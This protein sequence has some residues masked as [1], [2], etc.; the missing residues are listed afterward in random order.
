MEAKPALRNKTR[1]PGSDARV[2]N[3]RLERISVRSRRTSS[4]K[5]ISGGQHSRRTCGTA[6]A[7]FNRRDLPLRI[8]RVLHSPHG[9]NCFDRNSVP[10]FRRSIYNGLDSRP[11]LC[12]KGTSSTRAPVEF[13]LLA[14][15][16]LHPEVTP[17][18]RVILANNEN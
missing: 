17:E 15:M 10:A 3:K 7:L 5:A 9:T 2:G 13:S 8:R 16:T 4:H 12:H 18:R 1:Y 6:S 11:S 14:S